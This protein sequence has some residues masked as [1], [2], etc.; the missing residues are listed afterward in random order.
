[1]TD[2]RGLMNAEVDMASMYPWPS[3]TVGKP[4]GRNENVTVV[5]AGIVGS[6][7]A[8]CLLR[9]GYDVTIVD[10][11]EPGLG[12][13]F[14]NA[15]CIASY[16]CTPIATPGI[17]WKVPRM[18]LDPA[19]PLAIRWSYLPRL[20]NWL[21]RFLLSSRRAR[22]NE[23]SASLAALLPYV[24]PAY[25]MLLGA[26][27]SRLIHDR[28]ALILLPRGSSLEEAARTLDMHR[29]HGVEGSLLSPA[30]VRAAEPNLEETYAG[31][32]LFPGNMHVGNPHA[33][34]QHIFGTFL[35][36]GG[37]FVRAEVSAIRRA[38]QSYA[39]ATSGGPR[40]AGKV[41]LSAGAWSRSLLSQLGE[42][43]PLDTERGYHVTFD[44]A[45]ELISRPVC[46]LP[47]GFYMTPMDG[48][49]RVAGTVELGGLDLPPNS[50]RFEML[51]NQARKVLKPLKDP[52]SRWMGFRPSM[53]DSLPVI[54]E[55]ARSRNLYYAFGHGHLGLSFAA[56]TGYLLAA[57]VAGEPTPI[58][59][60]PYAPQRF[61]RRSQGDGS[62]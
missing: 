28:G 16:E 42:D 5:G 23:I 35:R 13:S 7:V 53:P 41:V 37:T 9:L 50:A 43:L 25:D 54:G 46:V 45:Q 58:G 24:R 47:T 48:A 51:T 32:L 59:M 4:A 30:E 38:D 55:S 19:G 22:F 56:V 57:T 39:L 12:A 3:S 34:V 62:A 21:L 10:R 44:G 18:L 31:A 52:D 33:F 40:K 8:L 36:E 14:G 15:G 60:S 11:A 61:Q 49:L 2:E 17:A 29:S 26:D 6:C 1:M 20:S 27:A